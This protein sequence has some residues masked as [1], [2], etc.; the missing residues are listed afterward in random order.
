MFYDDSIR[1][2]LLAAT[3]CTFLA[4]SLWAL[5]QPKSLATTL[6]YELKSSNS[7]SEFHAIYVGVFL[8]QALLCALAF[9]RIEDAMLGNLVAIFLL[10]QPVGRCIAL[11]RGGHTTGILKLLFLAEVI[12]GLILLAVQPSL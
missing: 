10:A 3:G 6:G 11:L 9:I 12:G 5:I 2:I 4:F 1:Q 7:I 8:A